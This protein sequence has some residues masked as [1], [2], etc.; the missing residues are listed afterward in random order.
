MKYIEINHK[1]HTTTSF[2]L[3][4]PRTYADKKNLKCKR[5]VFYNG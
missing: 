5:R 2:F 3:P 4:R 1:Y